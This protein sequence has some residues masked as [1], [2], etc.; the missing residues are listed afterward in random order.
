MSECYHNIKINLDTPGKL[1]SCVDVT[2]IL[3]MEDSD[4]H[5]QI[6]NEVTKASLTSNIIVQVNKGYKKCNKNLEKQ[7]SEYDLGHALKNAFKYALNNGL[8]RI[9]VLEDDCEFDHKTIA[10][11][12]TCQSI[13][14]FL[15]HR[16][17]EVYDIG[18]FGITFV[19]MFP[20]TFKHFKVNTIL[21]SES[22]IYNDIHMRKRISRP[23]KERQVDRE[24]KHHGNKFCYFIPLSA[25]KVEETENSKKWYTTMGINNYELAKPL[26][27]LTGY[28]S[29]PVK[30]KQKC[31]IIANLFMFVLI[32]YILYKLLKVYTP[33]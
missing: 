12:E 1:D 16:D 22:I 6:M 21:G 20:Y 10:Y 30:V 2:I 4:R 33:I 25:Q 17:P 26:L 27:K 13:C 11:P 32:S 19:N 23:D 31:Y 15:K 8:K 7:S 9:L 3:T 14:N 28:N 5:E 18:H 29:D 24:L